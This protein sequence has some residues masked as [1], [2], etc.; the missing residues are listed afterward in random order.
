MKVGII[1]LCRYNSTRLPGKILKKIRGKSILGN[2]YERLQTSKVVHEIIVATSQESSDDIISDYCNDQSIPCFRGDL[3]NVS[4]RFLDCALSNDLDY[5]I[6]INGDNIFIDVDTL[7]QLVLDATSNNLHFCSNV[8]G[9]TFPYGM[10]IEVVNTDFYSKCYKEFT[11]PDH[12]EHVTKYL[13]DHCD[14]TDD[15]HF[16]KNTIYPELQG[17]QMAVDTL[18]DF[19]KARAIANELENFPVSYSMKSIANILKNKK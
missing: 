15:F 17:V 11:N 10:S 2:I 6:R 19:E 13:Y 3:N 4:K 7:D 16:H 8:P 12:F 9:R 5:A 1:I 18:E 14:K